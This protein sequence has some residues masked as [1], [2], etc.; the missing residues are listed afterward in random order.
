MTNQQQD[1]LL[2]SL[3][4]YLNLLEAWDSVALLVA[5][6]GLALGDLDHHHHQIV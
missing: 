4:H 2:A 5:Y 6:I 3:F 1:I